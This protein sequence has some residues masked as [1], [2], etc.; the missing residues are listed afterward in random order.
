[1]QPVLGPLGAAVINEGVSQGKQRKRK[2]LRNAN[3][4]HM[5]SGGFFSYHHYY[6]HEESILTSHNMVLFNGG[7]NIHKE[8]NLSAGNCSLT[9]GP[10]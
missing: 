4:I 9:V 7:T 8:K 2:R 3:S 10:M 6:I 1:M 5:I